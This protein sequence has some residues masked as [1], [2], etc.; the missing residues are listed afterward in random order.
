MGQEPTERPG[1]ALADKLWNTMCSIYGTKRWQAEFGTHDETGI[2]GQA[3]SRFHPNQIKAA[4]AQ[5]AKHYQHRVPT[6]GQFRELC[7]Q[8][9]NPSDALQLESE[10]KP[11]S[12]DDQRQWIKDLKAMQKDAAARGPLSDEQR[13]FHLKTI[14]LDDETLARKN[15]PW[16]EPGTESACAYPGCSRPGTITIQGQNCR[17][18]GRHIRL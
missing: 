14:G 8:A 9:G 12:R 1:V 17:Y 5:C 10:R 18:C 15:N 4:I 7:R 3:L 11:I 13:E 6:L 2:W 16:V